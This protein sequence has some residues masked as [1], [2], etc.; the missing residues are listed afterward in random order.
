MDKVNPTR[1]PLL[2]YV[3][4]QPVE[5]VW[6]PEGICGDCGFPDDDEHDSVHCPRRYLEDQARMALGFEG[7]DSI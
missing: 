4:P 2:R 3:A 7:W 1:D 6:P 5:H